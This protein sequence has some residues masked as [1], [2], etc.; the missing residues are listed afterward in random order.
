MLSAAELI[1]L[2]KNCIPELQNRSMGIK[3]IY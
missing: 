3:Y 2:E 1:T